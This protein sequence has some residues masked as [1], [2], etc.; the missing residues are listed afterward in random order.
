MGE[1]NRRQFLVTAG[2]LTGTAVAAGLGSARA[3]GCDDCSNHKEGLQVETKESTTNIS[4]VPRTMRVAQMTAFH[5]PIEVR[6]I[7]VAAPRAD[8]ALVRVEASG[9]CRSDWH[10]WNQP[11]LKSEWVR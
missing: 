2:A 3:A 7:P 4:I 9:I 8:G 1:I 11:L 6:E 10:F 5:G